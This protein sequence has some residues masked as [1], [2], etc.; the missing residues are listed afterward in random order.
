MFKYEESMKNGV[1]GPS[2]VREGRRELLVH[3]IIMQL[4]PPTCF[5]FVILDLYTF[6]TCSRMNLFSSPVEEA[7][8]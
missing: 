5:Q 4:S 6:N 7:K 2:S 1:R 3:F 8:C